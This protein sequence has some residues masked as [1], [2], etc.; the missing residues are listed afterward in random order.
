MTGWGDLHRDGMPARR[1]KHFC[2]NA[3]LARCRYNIVTAKATGCW[4]D[5]CRL[6]RSGQQNT[7]MLIRLLLSGLKTIS[8]VNLIAIRLVRIHTAR[9]RSLFSAPMV[10]LSPFFSPVD[11]CILQASS[12]FFEKMT[13]FQIQSFCYLVGWLAC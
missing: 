12:Y 7:L 2:W 3:A 6:P 10:I 4:E 11:V 13:M 1:N 5:P 9:T 8:C